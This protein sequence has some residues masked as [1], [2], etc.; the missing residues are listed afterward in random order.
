METANAIR[1]LE[2]EIA[3]AKALKVEAELANRAKTEF[4]A[5]MSHEVRTPMSG[6]IGM[7][8]ILL[9]TKLDSEQREMAQTIQDASEP[10]KPGSWRA[11]VAVRKSATQTCCRC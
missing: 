5:N 1:G 11:R 9:D 8:R 4:L 6:I 3:R 10:R 2:T 7:V